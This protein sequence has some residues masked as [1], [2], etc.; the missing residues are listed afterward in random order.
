MPSLE[1]LDAVR[2]RG[3]RPQVVLCFVFEKRVLM[4][5]V[6]EH[7][8]WQ[9][10]QGGIDN[11]ESILKALRRETSEELGS[12]FA[13]AISSQCTYLGE[14]KMAFPP[15]TQGAKPLQTDAGVSVKMLG[16]KYFLVAIPVSHEPLL[17]QTS[18]FD[19]I[20][21]V[22]HAGGIERAATIYQNGKRRVTEFTLHQLREAQL[23]D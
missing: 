6:S 18:Q 2:A 15:Q 20:L 9:L 10:P 11:G 13:Q 23:I 4:G 1:E 17:S 8:L 12:A 14:T 22:N 7:A 21:W 3:Y 19:E 5:F 16:K